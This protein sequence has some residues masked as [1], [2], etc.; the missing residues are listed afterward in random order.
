[1]TVHYRYY[2][3]TPSQVLTAL[4]QSLSQ[5][6]NSHSY[7]KVGI[8]ADPDRRWDEHKRHDPTWDRMHVVYKT[9]S[10]SFVTQVE[11]A[12]I[13]HSRHRDESW[14]WVAGGGGA[15]ADSSVYYVYFLLQ[16]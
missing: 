2:T 4:K 7:F 1:M 16:R 9:S 3:G 12:L 14:N 13:D 8:T 11:T 5:L 10:Y 15:Q 6:A